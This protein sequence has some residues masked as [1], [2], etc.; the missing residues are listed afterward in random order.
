MAGFRPACM[1][2]RHWKG[3]GARSEFGAA[4]CRRYGPA[5]DPASRHAPLWPTTQAKD[6]CG[7]FK[8]H[9]LPD[10][11]LAEICRLLN[12]SGN[13]VETVLE[14]IRWLQKRDHDLAKIERDKLRADGDAHE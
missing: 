13:P 8:P 12:V 11:V 2:C 10:D 6:A 1:N 5:V 4:E 9:R 14:N 3:A 7:E